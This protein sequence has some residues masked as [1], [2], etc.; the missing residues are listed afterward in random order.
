MKPTPFRVKASV[1]GMCNLTCGLIIKSK[2]KSC[3]A[4]IWYHKGA[5]IYDVRNGWGEGGPQK[6]DE[7]NEVALI[8]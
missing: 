1:Q 2:I 4:R 6:A 8:L 5:S 3:L 7:R